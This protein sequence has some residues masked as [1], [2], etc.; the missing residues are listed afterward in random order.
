MKKQQNESS[1]K[2]KI[3]KLNYIKHKPD[4]KRNQKM[5]FKKRFRKKNQ[6]RLKK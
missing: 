1:S 5:D 3:K 2:K 4:T 6:T